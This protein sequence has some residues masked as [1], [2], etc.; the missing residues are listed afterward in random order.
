LRPAATRS[1]AAASAVADHRTANHRATDLA[2]YLAAVGAGIAADCGLRTADRLRAADGLRA[3]GW[4]RGISRLTV[5]EQAKAKQAATTATATTITK[6]IAA[7]R[8]RSNYDHG[9]QQQH[10]THDTSPGR[11][12][13]RNGWPV[14]VTG[15]RA[16]G[17][18]LNHSP[19]GMMC[20]CNASIFGHA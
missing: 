2:A 14:E 12:F 19:R 18:M 7:G 9:C 15:I 11:S 5:T 13:S 3:T 1:I 20:K 8:A 10:L 17:R 16:G 6:T 4:R